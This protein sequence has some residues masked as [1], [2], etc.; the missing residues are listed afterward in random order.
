MDSYREALLRH[1]REHSEDIAGIMR[2]VYHLSQAWAQEHHKISSRLDKI[3][4]DITEIKTAMSKPAEFTFSHLTKVPLV[5]IAFAVGATL[6]AMRLPDQGAEFLLGL[7][8]S[9]M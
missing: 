4:R 5:K 6:G 7:L 9:L 1:L 2:E 3:D 8:K